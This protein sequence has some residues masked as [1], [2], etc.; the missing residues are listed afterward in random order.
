LAEHWQ[1]FE[2][3]VA[4]KM[5]GERTECSGSTH[6]DN[7]VTGKIFSIECKA[8][9]KDQTRFVLEL[10]DWELAVEKATKEALYPAMAVCLGQLV[11]FGMSLELFKETAPFYNLCQMFEVNI[12]QFKSYPLRAYDWSLYLTSAGRNGRV[13][14]L[15]TRF[16]RASIDL[17]WM[18]DEHFLAINKHLVKEEEDA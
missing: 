4:T 17:V 6:G 2:E 7:D 18:A 1:N 15:C 8:P 13:P 16:K 12:E 3:Y 5:G 14:V 10:S 11:L 9:T